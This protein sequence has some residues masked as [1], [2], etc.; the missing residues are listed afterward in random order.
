MLRMNMKYN[1][2]SGKGKSVMILGMEELIDVVLSNVLDNKVEWTFYELWIGSAI[3][4]FVKDRGIAY[5]IAYVN[6]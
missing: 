4:L 6:K 2:K 5:T 3:W 1:L